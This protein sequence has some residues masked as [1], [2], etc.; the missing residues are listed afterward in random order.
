LHRVASGLDDML[1]LLQ[2]G[3]GPCAI[4]TPRHRTLRAALDWSYVL[5]PATAQAALRRLAALASWFTLEQAVALLQPDQS[6]YDTIDSLAV[7]AA[8]SLIAVAHGREARFRLLATTRAYAQ[9]LQ[10]A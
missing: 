10:N 7:L 3:G 2:C 4:A 8:H 1:R 5:L 6:P 9:S